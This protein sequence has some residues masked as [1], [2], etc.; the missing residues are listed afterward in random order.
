MLEKRLKEKIKKIEMK[1]GFEIEG[2]FSI[3]L[4]E[5]M[6]NEGEFKRDYSVKRGSIIRQW[7]LDED[8]LIDYDEF[9]SKVFED[10]DEMVEILSYFEAKNGYYYDKEE[11]S[12]GLHFHVSLP[13][14]RSCFILASDW[15]KFKKFQSNFI[16]KNYE[17]RVEKGGYCF[18]YKTKQ[19][20]LKGFRMSEKYRVLRFHPRG[21]LEFRFLYPDTRRIEAIDETL[22]FLLKEVFKTEYLKFHSIIDNSQREKVEYKHEIIL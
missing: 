8:D 11:W 9:S 7:N 15:N 21:T 13:N 3:E 22:K 17:E 12:S 14:I 2:V 19:A 6:K 16:L 4:Y 20:F 10:Y 1:M 5:R 18:A